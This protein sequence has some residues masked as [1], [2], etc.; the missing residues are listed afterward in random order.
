MMSNLNGGMS[1]DPCLYDII[2]T[3]ERLYLHGLKILPAADRVGQSSMLANLPA[4]S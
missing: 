2:F 4:L 3:F 1:K